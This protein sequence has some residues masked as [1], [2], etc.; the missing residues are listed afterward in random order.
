MMD[1]LLQANGGGGGGGGDGE[2]STSMSTCD[3]PATSIIK[4]EEVC[5]SYAVVGCGSICNSVSCC[6]F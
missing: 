4:Q 6:K 2:A 3:L 5:L 1:N